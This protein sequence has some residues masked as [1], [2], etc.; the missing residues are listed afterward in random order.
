MF[1]FVSEALSN[2]AYWLEKR[3]G[4]FFT[5][6]YTIRKTNPLS[7]KFSINDVE[8]T[9]N[10]ISLVAAINAAVASEL[11]FIPVAPPYTKIVIKDEVKEFVKVQANHVNIAPP[12]FLKKPAFTRYPVTNPHRMLTSAYGKKT[13]LVTI[14]KNRLVISPQSAATQGPAKQATKTVPIMSRNSGSFNAEQRV[15]PIKLIPTA[16]GINT[17]TFVEKFLWRNA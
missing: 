7:I 10:T 4:I 17:S 2:G 11:V 3:L 13:G 14:A 6:Q 16:I 8:N 12:M 1:L 15:P 9:E 5:N